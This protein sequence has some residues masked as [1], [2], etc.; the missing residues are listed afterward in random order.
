MVWVARGCRLIVSGCVGWGDTGAC[1]RAR[2]Q[3]GCVVS[4]V[5]WGDGELDCRLLCYALP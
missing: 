3:V 5:G 2:S 1:V 4:G